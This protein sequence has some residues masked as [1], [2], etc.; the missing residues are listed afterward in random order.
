MCVCVYLSKEI[1]A[2]C[3][4]QCQWRRRSACFLAWRWR[5]CLRE[6]RTCDTLRSRSR[7][8]NR[9]LTDECVQFVDPSKRRKGLHN[10]ITSCVILLFI[11]NKCWAWFVTGIADVCYCY[12]SPS[13]LCDFVRFCLSHTRVLATY[14]SG[15][16]HSACL[17][18]CV[19]CTLA[20]CWLL[21]LLH[22]SDLL[23]NNMLYSTSIHI[24][25]LVGCLWNWESVTK[26]YGA[27]AIEIKYLITF[28]LLPSD[29]F[30]I[31]FIFSR[32]RNHLTK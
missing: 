27:V 3:C 4:R 7:S 32:W 17:V 30:T 26:K 23:H 29:C 18:P 19:L 31:C 6:R 11:P 24:W 2:W 8:M 21:Q 9:S 13:V 16:N 10:C 5:R 28:I 1:S 15:N 20:F 22:I 25:M 14:V 12:H